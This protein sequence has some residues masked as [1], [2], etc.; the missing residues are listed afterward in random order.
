MDGYMAVIMFI[1]MK[2]EVKIDTKNI[3]TVLLEKKHMFA[4]DRKV[5]SLASAMRSNINTQ[6]DYIN[7]DVIRI[8]SPIAEILKNA[9]VTGTDIYFRSQSDVDNY[10]MWKMI[11][12]LNKMIYVNKDSIVNYCITLLKNTGVLSINENIGVDREFL[13]TT[14]GTIGP[15]ARLYKYQPALYEA[16]CTILNNKVYVHFDDIFYDDFTIKIDAIDNILLRLKKNQIVEKTLLY[17]S[18]DEL[19]K[20]L[21][22]KLTNSKTLAIINNNKRFGDIFYYEL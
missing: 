4:D 10:E 16:S 1:A 3:T 15:A 19:E 21:T 12:T 11:T 8:P 13:D 9:V 5:S 18:N 17:V 6:C 7:K 20:I 22:K 14:H 2:G